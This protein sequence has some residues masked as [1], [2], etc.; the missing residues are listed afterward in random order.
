M[1]GRCRK[2]GDSV[3]IRNTVKAKFWVE[4]CQK[5]TVVKEYIRARMEFQK[6]LKVEWRQVT[7]GISGKNI[8]KC[9]KG[10]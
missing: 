10:F 2:S 7:D 3:K 8:E 5:N 9:E 4:N 1:I 6:S